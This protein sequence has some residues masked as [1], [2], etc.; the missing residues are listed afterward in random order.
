MLRCG[1][2]GWGSRLDLRL[3]QAAFALVT[4]LY[5]FVTPPFQVHDETNHFFKAYQLS[6]GTIFNIRQDPDLGNMLP[7]YVGDLATKQFTPEAV[8]ILP[9]FSWTNLVQVWR[10]PYDPGS[11]Q[12]TPFSNIAN[13]APTLYIPQALGIAVARGIGLPPLGQFYAGRLFNALFGITLVLSAVSL[14]PAGR[15]AM[16]AFA[17]FP[18]FSNQIGS[19][20][21]DASI[22][23]LS[24]LTIAVALQ[25]ARQRA[26]GRWIAGWPVLMSGLALA[27]GVYVPL[28]LAGLPERPRRWY[29]AWLA[30]S[31]TIGVAVAAVWLKLNSGNFIRQTFVDRKTLEHVAGA[32]PAEQLAYVLGHPMTY[33]HTLVT[34]FAERLPAY[35]IEAVGRFGWFTILLPIPVYALAVLTAFMALLAPVPS[36]PRPSPAQ[37]LY[38]LALLVGGVVLIETA[39][40]LTASPLGASYIQGA[41]GRYYLQYLPL[42]GLA[43]AVPLRPDSAGGRLVE[44]TLVPAMILL[45]AAGLAVSGVSF[46]A[47]S[48]AFNGGIV[49]NG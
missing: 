20:S 49:V 17:T 29:W 4:L 1:G 16:L 45:M 27:K 25:Q 6:E 28:A 36:N 39:L 3:A 10:A 23:G 37:R 42:A 11:R 8:N 32:L 35:A 9:V 40:Y 38:W 21:A 2:S 12:F 18:A 43:F 34:S 24:F 5:V 19:Y 30:A 22:I 31:L 13:Y 47:G 14:I 46:W 41:S 26:P 33:L 7:S 48:T 44:R 15:P